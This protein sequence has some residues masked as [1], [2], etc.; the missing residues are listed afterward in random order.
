[1]P[2]ITI[3]ANPAS[4]A[5]GSSSTLTVAATNATSITLT[6]SDG[7]TFSVQ[8][9][10]GTQAVKPAATTTY[11]ASANGTGGT[12]TA[13]AIVTVTAPATPPTVTIAASPSSI[14]AGTSSTL[15]VAATNATTVTVTGSDGSSYSLAAT[16][17]T[18]SVKPSL[19]TTY[20]A[21]A[22]GAGG[23]ATATAILTVTAGN[24]QSINHVVFMLQENHAFDNYF[25]MLNPYRASNNWQTGDD[26]KTYLI[27]GID[28]KLTT[29]SNQNDEGVV[30]PLFKLK[31]SCVDDES[32]GWLES[33]GDVSSYDFTPTRPIRMDGFV[34]DAEGFARSCNASGTC[35]GQYTDTAGKR[36]MG[37]Y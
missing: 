1:M 21:S 10:G 30:F 12:A 4:I 14:T 11:T 17:G 33:Y 6:G 24:A 27:D 9:S 19:T 34:H 13:T 25:G 5:A 16:G 26:G 3:A 15:T 36:A 7:S 22:T 32:S 35:V 28:D 23:S 20:T 29:I 31:S 37:Y 18:Q 8:P 2:T